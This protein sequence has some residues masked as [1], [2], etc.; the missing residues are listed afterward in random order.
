MHFF[1]IIEKVPKAFCD[2]EALKYRD[3]FQK[4][5][6][7]LTEKLWNLFNT[8]VFKFTEEQSIPITWNKKL[9]NTAGRC[10]TSKKF[11][12]R[13]ARIE[14]SDKVITNADRLRCTLVHELCH[15]ATWIFNEINGHGKEWKMW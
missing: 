1:F 8:N 15:A 5:K 6:I 13:T 4:N 14:L 3:N 9:T 10:M 12:K 7:E 2:S 11:G